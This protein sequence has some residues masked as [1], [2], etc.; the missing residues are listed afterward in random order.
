LTS[1]GGWLCEYSSKEYRK[2]GEGSRECR[3]RGR[4]EKVDESQSDGVKER[5]EQGGTR[6]GGGQGRTEIVD[7]TE[8][9]W[10][11][12]RTAS[13]LP[14]SELEGSVFGLGFDRCVYED[15]KGGEK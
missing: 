11:G 2:K 8:R 3:R 6:A 7:E 13:I 4:R 5:D 10:E 15:Q 1:E 14:V 9:I 12:R